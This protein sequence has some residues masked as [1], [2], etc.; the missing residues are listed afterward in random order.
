MKKIGIYIYL[1]SLSSGILISCREDETFETERQVYNNH[2]EKNIKGQSKS[3]LMDSTYSNQQRDSLN[4]K[5]EPV[6]T[7]FPIEEN[8]PKGIPPKK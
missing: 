7:V 5:M 3:S 2:S 4:S 1:F 8:E 6:D